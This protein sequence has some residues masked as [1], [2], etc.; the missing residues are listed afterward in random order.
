MQTRHHTRPASK[1]RSRRG[2]RPRRGSKSSRNDAA[3]ARRCAAQ[4]RTDR[5][6]AL[7][8]LGAEGAPPATASRQSVP[9]SARRGPRCVTRKSSSAKP[10]RALEDHSARKQRPN[11]Q[12]PCRQPDDRQLKARERVRQRLRVDGHGWQASRLRGKTA[13]MGGVGHFERCL[14]SLHYLERASRAAFYASVDAAAKAGA[15]VVVYA[16]PRV[17]S[18]DPGLLEQHRL[19]ESYSTAFRRHH[20]AESNSTA[21]RRLATPPMARKKPRSRFGDC[22]ADRFHHSAHHHSPLLGARRGFARAFAPYRGLLR[23]ARP[24][25]SASP[26]E[27]SASPE[28]GTAKAPRT[29][30]A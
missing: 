28:E 13:G 14:K 1:E 11:S 5:L 3:R 12:R 27:R 8:G 2:A 20:L 9:V 10:T 16:A 15:T 29:P 21:C 30:K 19:A 23:V 22:S 25:R 18:I 6:A 26:E 7:T 4:G 17:A 24:P